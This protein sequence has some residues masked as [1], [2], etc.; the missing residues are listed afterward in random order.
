[1]N[2][3]KPENVV[4]EARQRWDQG[5]A[6]NAEEYISSNPLVKDYKSIVLE[7]AYEEYFRRSSAG[8]RLD[9]S[10]FC[11][12]YSIC[13]TSLRRRIEVHEFLHENLDEWLGEETW[14]QTGERFNDF[15]LIR[16]LGRGIDSRVFVAR[17]Q[18]L[19]NR[20]VVLKFSRQG[21]R[22]A[23]M[24]TSLEHPNIVPV[25]S[26]EEDELTGLVAICMPYLTPWTLND[27][28]DTAFAEGA[29]PNRFAEVI[30]DLQ[31]DESIP[32]PTSEQP[33]MCEFLSDCTYY[34]G[35]LH[36]MSEVAGALRHTHE[37][38][39]LHLDL[40]PSNILITATGVPM[41]LDFNL[42]SA[43]ERNRVYGGTLPYMP[44][45][46]LAAFDSRGEAE[47][48][49]SCASDVY[50]LGVV[51]YQLLCGKLPY[52]SDQPEGSASALVKHLLSEQKLKSAEV[53]LPGHCV[54]HS[55]SRFIEQCLSIDAKARPSDMG[56]AVSELAASVAL[57]RRVW[58][59]CFAYRIAL[60]ALVLFG[61]AGIVWGSYSVATQAPQHVRWHQ[62][63]NEHLSQ[64]ESAKAVE[65]Y[66][67]A[68]DLAPTEDIYWNSR[69]RARQANNDLLGAIKDYE[70][71][72]NIRRQGEYRAR[73][74]HCLA[75]Q[76]DYAAATA[77]FEAAMDEGVDTAG[78]H[79]CLGR[80]YLAQG[81]YAA[82]MSSYDTA[83]SHNAD[84]WLAHYGLARAQKGLATADARRVPE[85][86]LVHIEESRK[87]NP[88]SWQVAMIAAQ[89]HYEFGK[90]NNNPDSIKRALEH[91][92]EG[93]ELGLP[94]QAL[95]SFRAIPEF[96]DNSSFKLLVDAPGHGTR[97]ANR[98]RESYLPDPILQAVVE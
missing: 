66:S 97:V 9:V 6:P 21:Y 26:V 58:R 27:F 24:M 29:P 28:L 68:I 62:R 96:R 48:L 85:S 5:E 88:K 7:L 73:I 31:R 79:L 51:T 91:L 63:G 84:S 82:A 11:Q 65:C 89:L 1:M 75:L 8:E 35:V 76:R 70:R 50:S 71:A 46:Q 38:G 41:V 93:V 81:N 77:L 43:A 61:F 54:D 94:K 39:I 95:D 87:L 23:R 45:E 53:D 72:Y 80:C 98:T 56:H 69:G 15:D 64:Q 78:L 16:E 40:K 13:G 52:G 33:S 57:P 25:L 90:T 30:S 12:R 59:K 74:A 2:L 36:I 60:S 22:E 47:G 20:L 10:R 44:H 86:V 32:A 67:K 37:R 49:I 83:L 42:S 55:T 34:D 4:D 3:L 18:S 92:E 19:S 14:P 17:Q